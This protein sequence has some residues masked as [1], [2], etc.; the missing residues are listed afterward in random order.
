MADIPEFRRHFEKPDIEKLFSD[1]FA[2]PEDFLFGVA[3]SGYQTEGGYNAPGKPFNNWWK[4]ESRGRIERSGEATRFWDDYEKDIEIARSTGVNAFR[5]GVEWARVQPSSTSGLIPPFDDKAIEHYSKI[6][7]FIMKAEMEPVLTL[8]HFTHPLWLGMDFWL[9]RE[10]L[11]HFDPFVRKVVSDLNKSLIEKHGLRPIKYY[12]TI[13]EPN[14]LALG[15]YLIRSLPGKKGIGIHKSGRAWGNMLAAHCHAYDIIHDLYEEAGWEEPLVTYNTS[16]LSI[17]W[18]DKFATDLL[19]ARINEVE[20]A[21][22]AD[23]FQ[24]SR[25]SWDEE[26]NLC[27]EVRKASILSRVLERLL[28]EGTERL[29]SLEDF[30]NAIDALYSSQLEKKLDWLAVDFYDPFFRNMIVFPTL[31]YLLDRG[32]RKHYFLWNQTLNPQALPHFLKGMCLNSRGIPIVLLENGMA[33]RLARGR[34]EQRRDRATRDA[35]LQ[36]YIF[37]AMKALKMGVP[38]SGYFHWTLFDNFEWGSYEP[39]FGLY[40]VDRTEGVG[41][42]TKDAWGVDAGAAYKEIISSLESGE[43]KRIVDAFTN[44]Y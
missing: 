11:E 9:D 34:V 17:Y 28:Y 42:K 29:F 32:A 19:N 37:E 13:N 27:P 40:A 16:Q 41:K 25:K 7:A 4:W 1:G 38:L 18:L 20:R 44:D 39:R 3:T 35:F 10:S 23:Y 36:C 14:A 15:T 26:I 43:Q 8:H 12:T 2:L 5:L 6:I 21:D 24:G 22:L 31:D 30:D 33:Y